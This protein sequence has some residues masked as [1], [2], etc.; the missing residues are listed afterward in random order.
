MLCSTYPNR[1]P[2]QRGTSSVLTPMLPEA[3]VHY[4]QNHGAESYAKVY[5]GEH[6][7]PEVIWNAEMRWKLLFFQLKKTCYIYR[8]HLIGRLAVHVADFSV[9]LKSNVRAIYQYCPM[10]EIQVLKFFSINTTRDVCSTHSLRT[11]CS[12]TFTTCAICATLRDSP[13][14]QSRMLL[15]C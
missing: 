4:L 8:R 7:N 11:S 12:V 1:A 3:C 15:L 10:P 2:M 13:I 14:G 6:D 5:L 9:R